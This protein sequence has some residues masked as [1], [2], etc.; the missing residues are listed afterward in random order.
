MS[1]RY[2]RF[3]AFSVVSFVFST[4]LVTL[5]LLYSIGGGSKEWSYSYFYYS[6]LQLE[7]LL[8]FFVAYAPIFTSIKYLLQ[9][10]IPVNTLNTI[11]FHKLS[12]MEDHLL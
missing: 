4:S 10:P 3:G 9:R 2:G 7:Q 1:S 8:H 11:S 5:I 6:F 12:D